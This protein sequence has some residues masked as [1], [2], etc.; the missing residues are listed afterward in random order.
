MPERQ[1]LQMDRFERGGGYTSPIVP[2]SVLSSKRQEDGGSDKKTHLGLENA[3]NLI[4][5]HLS[6]KLYLFSKSKNK[7]G[8][9]PAN[10]E[11]VYCN[12]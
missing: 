11:V 3:G 9:V 2:H 4:E 7:L 6:H 5:V 8:S 10:S 1:N 12:Q